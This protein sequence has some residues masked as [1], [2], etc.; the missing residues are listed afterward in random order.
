[1]RCK[2]CNNIFS[3][4]KFQLMGGDVLEEELCGNCLGMAFD[5][6]PDIASDREIEELLRSLAGDSSPQLR[7]QD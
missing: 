3:P 6:S 1:M 7:L 2:A 4:A 5:E